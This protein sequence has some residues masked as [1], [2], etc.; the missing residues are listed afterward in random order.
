[1]AGIWGDALR[2]KMRIKYRMDRGFNQGCAIIRGVLQGNMKFNRLAGYGCR[3][4]VIE[5]SFI[6]VGWGAEAV[7]VRMT[8]AAG[9]YQPGRWVAHLAKPNSDGPGDHT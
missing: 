3:F 2:R 9:G 8:G 6:R 5:L 7:K 1:M 4:G